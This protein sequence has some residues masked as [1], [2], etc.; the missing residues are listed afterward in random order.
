MAV[1]A[2]ITALVSVGYV[3]WGVWSYTGDSSEFVDSERHGVTYARPLTGLLA[4]LVD[5]ETAAVRGKPVD[6]AAVRSAVDDV[7][8]VDGQLGS[9][10]GVGQRWSKV[11][12]QVESALNSKATGQDALNAYAAPIALTRALLKEVGDLT[13]VVRDPELEAFHLVDAALFRVPD[14]IVDAGEISSV[15]HIVQRAADRDGDGDPRVAVAQARLVTAADDI[16][17]GLRMGADTSAGGAIDL[18]LLDPLDRFAAAVDA[19]AKTNA[20]RADDV[21]AARVGVHKAAVGLESAVLAALDSALQARKDALGQQR[22]Y[23][24][25][26]GVLGALATVALLWLSSSGSATPPAPAAPTRLAAGRRQGQSADDGEASGDL[27]N[28]RD[29]HDLVGA[30]GQAPANRR[31][32]R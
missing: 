2:L 30:G 8:R 1:I 16:S 26:A 29:L 17:V 9:A 15:A 7:S 13:R 21:D 3:F 10:L 32:A 18:N 4:A 5:A 25:V 28:A 6:A 11:P 12:G 20:T 23:A 27:I 24:V 31:R 14:V 19:L 22:T